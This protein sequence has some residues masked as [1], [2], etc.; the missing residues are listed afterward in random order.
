MLARRSL[1]AALVLLL[2]F[3]ALA[4]PPAEDPTQLLAREH[5]QQAIDQAGSPRAVASL[6]RLHALRDELEDLSVLG[7][8]YTTVLARR[9]SDPFV[10]TAA[11]LY[12]MDLERARGR[13][14]RAAELG[15]ELGF[16]TDFYVLGSF[17]NEGKAGCATDFGPEANAD[18]SARF[19][20]QGRETG[21]RK[22]PV[23]SEGGYVDL[24][25]ALRPNHEAVAYALTYLEA[26][27]DTRVNL[28]VGTSGG[29][30]LF[31]NGQL[32]AS[33]DD[34]NLPR[35]DQHRV[36][37]RLG[38]GANR[39]LLKVCQERGP[40]G[41]YLR[42]DAG[43]S[44]T[45]VLPA[46]TPATV[47]L[48]SQPQQL[49]TLTR[50]VAALVKANPNDA[51][52][53]SDY[54]TVLESFRAFDQRE[55][56]DV[57][58][59]ARAA[60]LAPG[61]ARVQRVAAELNVEDHNLRRQ[62][63]EA[64]LALEPA[65]VH[66]RLEL[67]ELEL[68]RNHPERALG[69]LQQL[70]SEKPTLARARVLLARTY[71]ELGELAKSSLILEQALRDLPRAPSVLNP[72]VRASR[73]LDRPGEAIDRLRVAVALRF[74]DVGNRAM[75]ASMLADVGRV[76]DAVRELERALTLAP[77]DNGLRV[78]LAQLL[79]ANGKIDRAEE[80]FAQARALSPDEPDLYEHQGRALL[81]ANRKEEALA[82]FEQSLVLRPQN[83]TLKEAVRWLKGEGTGLGTQYLVEVTPALSKQADAFAGEDAVYLV[84]NSYIRVQPTGLSSRLHQVAVKVYSQRGVDAW[85]SYPIT[86]SPNRQEVR[87]L[88]ARITKPDG[89]VVESYGDADRNINEP[90]SGMYYD[91]RARV[92]SFPSLAAGDVLELQ[93]RLEDTAQENLLSDYW[94]DVDYVQSTSPKLKYRFQ[95]DMPKNRP[96]YWN[97][98]KLGA[99]IHHEEEPTAEGRV[100]YHW[101]AE[102]VSKV[103]PEPMMPGW[104]EVVTTLHVSTYQTWEQVGRYYWGLVR[105]QLT[106]N[107][108]LRNTVEQVLAKVDRK[109]QFAVVQAIY[110]FVVTNTRYVALEFGIHGFKPYRVDRVL[111]RRFGDCKDKASLIHAMLKVAGVDSRLVLLRMRHLGSIGEEP[112]SLAAFNHAIV[113]I[114]QFDLYLDGTAEFH[115]AKELPTADRVANVL[116]VEPEKK[117][118][119]LTTP[120]ALASDNVTTLNL[121]VALRADGSAQLK[122]TNLVQGEDAPDY[123]RAYQAQHTRKANLEQSWSRSFPGLTVQEISLSDLTQL[124]SNV[125][126]GFT[127]VAPR[128]A[129]S[130]PTTLRFHPFGSGRGYTQ[131][132]APLAERSFDLVTSSPWTHRFR[133]SYAL[134]AGFT[135]SGAFQHKDESP[136]G[137]L[138]MDC[139]EDGPKLLCEGELAMSATR[140]KAAD[141]PKFRA[142]LGRVDQAFSRKIQLSGAPTTAGR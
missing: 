92:L 49:P 89:S 105:D 43:P 137:H 17:D 128:Y 75:L 67:A 31:V 34:Y 110:G 94:G 106:P 33:S 38:K 29:F 45:A 36:S 65:S 63:L 93:Y 41:F 121:E 51:G 95:V 62:Y 59:A 50:A 53:R 81:H 131:S 122:G 73:R 97:K 12:L 24:G 88:K 108:E 46:T 100:V 3:Q 126:L 123:R 22:L 16:L 91:A 129:E 42:Q 7:Q 103:V 2:S 101:G 10:R 5:G 25:T 82:S 83:P 112:A 52:L 28:G 56:T 48:S 11:R 21:W 32:A 74:D 1:P 139:K 66:A 141:Y 9:R 132:L 18:L 140:I 13:M 26:S 99:G 55:H 113:W 37:V 138:K 61:D 23:K 70:V 57:A 85:R 98:T 119:F 14:N 118:T 125:E 60:A 120:E 142:F 96:L 77:F 107:D 69:V 54:A 111:A 84:D 20:V 79:A 72:A 130:S 44:G 90:W 27:S 64:A 114:P 135:P 127:M 136:F 6:A 104:A 15:T 58:E 8:T 102:N 40:L 124:E 117:S 68:E 71:E 133:Y 80:I 76:D 134:P 109:D 86:Y 4:V 116:I 115:G 39:I 30:K 78:N 87:I 47:R 19:Q 35:P